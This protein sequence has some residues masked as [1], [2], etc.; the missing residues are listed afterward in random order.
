MINEQRRQIQQEALQALRDNQYNGIVLLP[1]GLGKSWVLI[2]ALQELIEF[3]PEAKIWYLCNSRN[4][5]DGGFEE[6]L[7][8]WG[9][10]EGIRSRIIKMCYQTAYKIRDEKV[11]IL[12]ADEFDYSLTPSYSKVYENNEFSHK[13]LVSATIDEQKR[14]YITSPIVYTAK[15]DEVEKIGALNKSAY[16]YV[17]FLMSEAEAKEYE[18]HNQRIRKLIQ[19]K[20]ELEFLLSQKPEL[21]KQVQHIEYQIQFAILQRKQF[22]NS[23]N[24]SQE[25]CKK[26]MKEI[27]SEDKD[28]KILIFC[29]LTSQADNICKWSYHTNSD[30]TN[31]Q[32]FKNGEIPAMSVCG[33][34]NR[35]TNIKGVNYMIFESCNQSS[36]QLVQRLG[37]GKRLMV[38]DRLNV[39]FLVPHY[40][41]NGN[42]IIATKV[43]DWIDNASK[44]LDLSKAKIYKFKK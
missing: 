27:Y 23:L 1:T 43:R 8:K 25:V 37:R 33:K 13:I 36:T 22:L 7:I 2:Q 16:Y 39:Y 6:E 38:Q 29:E 14:K 3:N 28:C 15:L 20:N 31:L 24:S 18:N 4:L 17:N 34:I 21:K 12:L 42:Y 19:R 35:G 41:K 44:G 40:K 32:K 11:D 9:I 10:D 26:L 30:Q 5:R